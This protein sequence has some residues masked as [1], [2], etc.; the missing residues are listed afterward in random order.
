MKVL[1][2]ED[3]VNILRGITEV[4]TSDKDFEQ[5]GFVRLLVD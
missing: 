2:A 1:V 5:E 3:D 4:L